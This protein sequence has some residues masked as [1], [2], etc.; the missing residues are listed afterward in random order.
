MGAADLLGFGAALA[1]STGLTV[2]IVRE[3]VARRIRRRLEREERIPLRRDALVQWLQ[4]TEHSGN[5]DQHQ[6]LPMPEYRRKA[7]A[8]M[9]EKYA[10]L[11]SRQHQLSMIAIAAAYLGSQHPALQEAFARLNWEA[12]APRD[13]AKERD[14]T[15][16]VNLMDVS[17]NED[18]VQAAGAV[19]D[20]LDALFRRLGP[21][22][23]HLHTERTPLLHGGGGAAE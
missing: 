14:A 5:P 16:N 22:P 20:G 18:T 21:P 7:L 11:H 23:D 10:L 12:T 6:G 8:D 1:M 9:F 3:H 2:S 17:T 15:A 19:A 4:L 13:A